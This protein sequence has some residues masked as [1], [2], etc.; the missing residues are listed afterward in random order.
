MRVT[1]A[2]CE[3]CRKDV[4]ATIVKTRYKGTILSICPICGG[5]ARR[6]ARMRK[7]LPYDIVRPVGRRIGTHTTRGIQ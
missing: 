4:E 2:Y 5:V 6:N 3:F 7:N 1:T